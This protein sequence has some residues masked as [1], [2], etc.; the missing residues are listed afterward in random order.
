VLEVAYVLAVGTLYVLALGPAR[1]LVRPL[2]GGSDLAT[3]W[4]LFALG[5]VVGWLAKGLYCWSQHD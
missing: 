5:A 3:L 2:L 4:A 1:E